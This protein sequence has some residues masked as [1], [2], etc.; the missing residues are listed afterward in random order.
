M[1][2]LLE[3]FKEIESFHWW[4]RGRRR[5]IERVVNSFCK[6]PTAVLEIGCGTGETLDFLKKILPESS[7]YGIDHSQ[8]AVAF[9]KKVDG[10]SV[11]LAD[12]A[13]LP[14]DNSSFDLVLILDVLEHIAD[15]SLVIREI[16]RVLTKGGKLVITCPA[17]GLIWSRHD[18][19][20]GHVRRYSPERICSLCDTAG[21][22]VEFVNYYNFFLFF[23]IAV[24][25]TLGNFRMFSFLSKYD[26]AIN[27]GL[28]TF[29][30]L[31]AILT[32]LIMLEV[33]FMFKF[34]FPFG[35]SVIAVARK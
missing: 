25:R 17:S 3:K 18:T 4:W 10:V 5:I 16:N 14:F 12:A 21:L 33:F 20:Q 15:D 1:D 6:K 22:K 23:P 26:D 31:N 7:I 2:E 9:S 30:P 24:I 19:R 32:K 8:V 35:V 34:K 13:K 11:V 28:A 27:Y 29:R